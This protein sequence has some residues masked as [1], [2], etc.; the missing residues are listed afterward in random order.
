LLLQRGL[1]FRSGRIIMPFLAIDLT[2]KRVDR[3]GIRVELAQ[4]FDGQE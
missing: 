2:H 3:E 1:I 4:P